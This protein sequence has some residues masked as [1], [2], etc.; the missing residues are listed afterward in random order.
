MLKKSLIKII[1]ILLLSMLFV[2][3]GM[4]TRMRALLGAKTHVTVRI[5]NNANQNNPVAVSLILVHD[6]ALFAKLLEMPSKDW[7]D[8]RDQIKRDYR[9][10]ESLDYWEWEWVPG[11]QVPLQELALKPGAVGGLVFAN[12]LS[13]GAHRVRIVPSEDILIRLSEKEFTVEVL[14]K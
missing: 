8:K 12:Y 10:G 2:S 6:E 11:Q 13:P 1:F 4:G 7:F 3:C 14:K 5:D 9:E